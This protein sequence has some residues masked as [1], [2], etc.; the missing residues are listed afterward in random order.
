MIDNFAVANLDVERLLSEWRWLCPDEM[1]LVARNVYGDLFLRGNDGGVFW[2]D[3]GGG[4]FQKVADSEGQ[5]RELAQTIAKKEEWFAASKVSA[6]ARR[7]LEP[8]SLQC[9]GFKTPVVFKE[10]ASVPDNAYV[11]DLYECVSFLGDLSHQI[12]DVPDGSKVRLIVGPKP[13][14]PD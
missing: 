10:S 3:V 11:A 7:G 12:A 2:L 6:A 1:E 5:F 8:N 4:R 13:G 9:I 14:E